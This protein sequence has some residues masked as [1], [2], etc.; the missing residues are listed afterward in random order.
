MYEIKRVL[1]FLSNT[2]PFKKK[3]KF[4]SICVQILFCVRYTQVKLSFG[5]ENN[6]RYIQCSRYRG[7]FYIR[8]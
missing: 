6:V 3:I 7:F 5:A 8:F 1:F 4:C 2:S